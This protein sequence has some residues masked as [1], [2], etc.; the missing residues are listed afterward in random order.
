MKRVLKG[1]TNA[2]GG[3][4][5]PHEILAPQL[6]TPITELPGLETPQGRS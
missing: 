1:I 5:I 2:I 3:R 4:H 6:K